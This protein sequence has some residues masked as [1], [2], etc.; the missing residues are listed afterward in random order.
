M[1]WQ[2]KSSTSEQYFNDIKIFNCILVMTSLLCPARLQDAQPVC[3]R[4]RAEGSWKNRRLI[5]PSPRARIHS[6]VENPPLLLVSLPRCCCPWNDGLLSH[7]GCFYD[8]S[9]PLPGAGADCPAPR[10][11]HQLWGLA[12]R[13]SGGPDPPT[14]GPLSSAPPSVPAI[15]TATRTASSQI[16]PAA[17]GVGSGGTECCCCQEPFK[18]SCSIPFHW[19]KEKLLPGA[20]SSFQQNLFSKQ[21]PVFLVGGLFFPLSEGAS[22]KTR[23][24]ILRRMV[25][26]STRCSCT[27]LVLSETIS[28]PTFYSTSHLFA[29]TEHSLSCGGLQTSR[30]F[31]A[32]FHHK[33]TAHSVSLF[34]ARAR[35]ARHEHQVQLP[36]AST[37]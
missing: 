1:S 12:W 2:L 17:V 31:S 18:I 36:M 4:L 5:N 11:A 27:L 35:A 37:C 15:P 9:Q 6:S 23:C 20:D 14:N 26:G 32:V 34:S 22:S 24:Y 8:L 25:K 16:P 28:I 33:F 10:R 7:I 30:P 3:V 13:L 19:S 29:C 21:T